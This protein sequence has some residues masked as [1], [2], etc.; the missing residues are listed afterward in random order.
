MLVEQNEFEPLAGTAPSASRGWFRADTISSKI[1]HQ[2][3]DFPLGFDHREFVMQR[4]MKTDK[5]VRTVT[6]NYTSVE[7]SRIP[8][9]SSSSSSSTATTSV[10]A[11]G[12]DSSS[13]ASSNNKRVKS[14]RA[15]TIN[16][17][18]HFKSI[19]KVRW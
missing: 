17:H 11:S 6:F 2:V 16:T 4:V 12:D 18:W 15:E 9:Y 13:S 19:A 14:I 7:D 5:K 3:F 10:A 8:P 1:I